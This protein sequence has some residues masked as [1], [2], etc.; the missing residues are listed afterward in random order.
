MT[1][2]RFG[3]IDERL[4]RR[5]ARLCAVLSV[6]VV[7]ALA[8]SSSAVAAGSSIGLHGPHSNLFGSS[9]QYT[10]FGTAKGAANYV[11]GWE[12]PYAGSCAG[13][14]TAESTRPSI[15]LFVSRSVAKNAPFSIVVH[16]SARNVERHRFCAYLIN[17]GSR[18][19]LAHAETTW[20]NY[21]GSTTPSSPSALAP[22]P[23]GSGQCQA[24]K[25]PDL[26][27]FA[28]IAISG[29]TTCAVL[30][31]VAY[32]SDAAKGA[33]YSRSGFSCTATT[34]GAGSKWAAAW[35]GT[36]YAYACVSGAKELAFN[37]G[38]QYAYVPAESLPTISPQS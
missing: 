21:A 1:A 30:D 24:A 29:G 35:T 15:F 3:G 12:V 22:A 5:P 25:F 8:L 31:S 23:V 19:T 28:Q 13:K 34:E 26:S 6:A 2:D 10:M 9:F 36:Y 16:F 17:K 32:G 14:Y 4:A 20:R 27:V 38:T 37:W 18:K 7:F 33:A 11:Y